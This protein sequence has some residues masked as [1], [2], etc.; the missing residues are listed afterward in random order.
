MAIE[1]PKK[2]LFLAL[3]ICSTTFWLYMANKQKAGTDGALP[4]ME[5]GPNICM[6]TQLPSQAVQKS[7]LLLFPD[8]ISFLGR[9]SVWCAY[10]VWEKEGALCWHLCMYYGL[11]HIGCR[12]M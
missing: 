1:N 11:V 9:V 7:H 8:T 5:E 3:L 10:N 6:C 4:Y 12:R 2:N